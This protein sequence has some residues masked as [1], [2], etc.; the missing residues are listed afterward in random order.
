MEIWKD[1]NEY[2]GLYQISNTGRVKSLE[3]MAK[4]RWDGKYRTI[5][6]KIKTPNCRS[7]Y[8][9]VGLSKDGKN[10]IYS[11]HRLVAEAFIPNPHNKPYINHKNGVKID[12]RV[13]NLEWCTHSENKKHSFATGL[14][15]NIGENH[16][17]SKF[18]D[19]DIRTIKTRLSIGEMGRYIAKDYGVAET[20]ISMIKVGKLWSH[21]KI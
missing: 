19:E 12:N 8:L 15:N 20:T 7:G 5:P 17:R 6:E 9:R 11:V 14:E 1:I 3:R 21:I 4:I 18:T 10:K 16:P 2:E 13:S